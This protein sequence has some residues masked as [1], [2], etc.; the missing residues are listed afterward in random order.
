MVISF[1]SLPARAHL[2]EKGMVYTFRKNRRKMLG[3]DWA[4]EGRLKP[5]MCDVYIEEL[6][7]I[8]PGQ[9]VPYFQ[10]SGFA[11]WSKWFDEIR[12]L[13]NFNYSV[14]QKG[15]LYKVTLKRSNQKVKTE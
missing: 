6:G 12:R 14:A 8:T 15:W 4:N 2:L 10:D 9:L 1:S 11:T 5:K 13:N 3:D 7:E